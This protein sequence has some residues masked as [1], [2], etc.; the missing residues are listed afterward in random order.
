MITIKFFIVRM[1]TWLSSASTILYTASLNSVAL[2]R[3]LLKSLIMFASLMSRGNFWLSVLWGWISAKHSSALSDSQLIHSFAFLSDRKGSIW[4]TLGVEQSFAC[5]FLW[6]SQETKSK[7]ALHL[8]P[9]LALHYW[10][11][12]S[13]HFWYWKPIW[14]SKSNYMTP[15]SIFVYLMF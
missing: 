3:F 12:K 8:F 11:E 13:T 4:W 2:L 15:I 6:S 1:E 14:H 5:Q 7:C 10:V 9:Q